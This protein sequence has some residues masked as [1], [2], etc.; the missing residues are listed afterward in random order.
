MTTSHLPPKSAPGPRL[1]LAV[2][3]CALLAAGCGGGAD[4]APESAASAGAAEIAEL[5]DAVAADVEDVASGGEVTRATALR[6]RNPTPAPAPSPAPTPAPAP[7]PAPSG[8]NCGLPDFQAAAL[9]RIN[10]YRAA[11]ANCRSAGR[12]ASAQPL[13]FDS[14][15]AQAATAHSQDMATRNYFSHTSPSGSTMVTRIN[16]A[17]YPWS[18]IGENIAAG[19][20]TVN[21]VIDGWMASDGHCANLMNPNFRDAALACVASSTSSYRTYWTLDLG[22][23]R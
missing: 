2:W 16:A 18:T 9:T 5:P 4:D 12:F 22:R 3:A 21:A 7:A 13:V 1:H 23:Q 15:L 17:G 6:R 20:G 10:A 8:A 19:Y 11:G 14:R